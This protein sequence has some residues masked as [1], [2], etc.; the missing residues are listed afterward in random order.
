ML[1]TYN[2]LGQYCELVNDFWENPTNLDDLDVFIYHFNEIFWKWEEDGFEI[3]TPKIK[4]LED[5]IS[6]IYH[7]GIF[8]IEEKLFEDKDIFKDKSFLDELAEYLEMLK[9]AQRMLNEIDLEFINIL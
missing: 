6:D 8:D 3:V 1:K 9:D 5:K 4:N 2:Y 7:T